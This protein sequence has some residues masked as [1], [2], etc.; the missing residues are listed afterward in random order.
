[1]G[2][3]KC[4]KEIGCHE[5]VILKAKEDMREFRQALVQFLIEPSTHIADLKVMAMSLKAAIDEWYEPHTEE[6]NK[7]VSD[8]SDNGLAE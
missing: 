6:Y 5:C 8:G 4:R 3:L 2:D 7:E 1:V